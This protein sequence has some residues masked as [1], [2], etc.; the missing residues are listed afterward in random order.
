MTTPPRNAKK[1]FLRTALLFL[2]IGILAA[3]GTYGV[4]WLTNGASG[5]VTAVIS[6]RF[7]GAER[8]LYPNGRPV[9][10]QILR[11][12]SVLEPALEAVNLSG[13][14]EAIREA[15]RV[16]VVPD[17]GGAPAAYRLTLSVSSGIKGSGAMILEEIVNSYARWL[18]HTQGGLGVIPTLSGFDVTQYEY[19]QAIGILDEKLHTGILYLREKEAEAPS[20]YAAASGGGFA[21]IAYDLT[22][23]RQQ[24]LQWLRAFVDRNAVVRDGGRVIL[25]LQHELETLQDRLRTVQ[26]GIE[27]L[28][29]FSEAHGGAGGAFDEA[30]FTAVL[31]QT[32]LANDLQDQMNRINNRLT[33]LAQPADDIAELTEQAGRE[34]AALI[35]QA[36][37]GLATAAAAVE[38][39]LAG[40]VY[41]S[42]PHM[43]RGPRYHSHFSLVWVRLLTVLLAI[44]AAGFVIGLFRA[45]GRKW[46]S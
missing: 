45:Y 13:Q 18:L 32:A 15:L 33:A 4:A 12:P 17:R 41:A 38:E 8:G 2:V 14:L 37:A 20:F 11:A 19:E 5:E 34:L 30:V 26:R 28:M 7:D 24:D 27:N 9:D 46:F 6:L 23:L 36:E 16:E 35:G 39:Y 44:T 21:Q 40:T 31:E 1:T 29:A 42:S 3:A 10:M 22:V 43:V 25:A